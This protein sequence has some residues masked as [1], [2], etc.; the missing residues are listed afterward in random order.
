MEFFVYAR[1]SMDTGKGESVENQI[2]MSREYI[3]TKFTGVT[4][5]DIKIYQ[6]NGYSGKNLE[7]PAFQQMLRDIRRLKPDYIICYRLDRISRSVSDFSALVEELNARGVSLVCIREEF[8]TS[9]PVGKAMMYIASVFAQLERETIAERVRDNMR[10]LSRTGRWLGGTAPLGYTPERVQDVILDGRVKSCCRLVDNPAESAIVDLIFEKF[11]ELRSVSGVSKYLIRQNVKNRRGKYFSPLGIKEILQ[12]PVYCA[13]DREAFRYFTGK[14]AEVCFDEKEC[15]GQF[16][17]LSYNKRDYSKKNV[18]RK[19]V[20]QWIIS[21]GRHKGRVTGK[22]WVEVQRSIAENIPAGTGSSR[23]R[24]GYS[25][26]SGLIFCEKCGSRMFAKMRSGSGWAKDGP[27]DYMCGNKL[28]GGTG[29]CGCPNINGKQADEIVC[30]RLIEYGRGD[31]GIYKMLGRLC[32]E[33]REQIGENPLHRI[34]LRLNRCSDEIDNLLNTL[35]QGGLSD[36]FIQSVNTRVAALDKER[37]A[38]A[39]EKNRLQASAGAGKRWEAQEK[40]AADALSNLKDNFQTLSV[41]EKRTFL[42]LLTRKI[43][44]DGKDL[45]VFMDGG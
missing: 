45:H 30:R 36:A 33:W 23:Q 15:T 44:W 12:N 21:I 42:R 37:K 3:R 40:Q 17:L 13:A 29:L 32:L 28:R 9:K 6:D 10:M 22:D 20:D 11:L 43:V 26:L 34:D 27:F 4:D 18:P 31:A 2:E 35:S 25:L 24:N 1:K 5:S 41:P 7:R 8:D 16:G 14:N 38:L 39:E 19:S